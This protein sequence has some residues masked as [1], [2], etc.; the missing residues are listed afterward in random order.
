VTVTIASRHSD[1]LRQPSFV[2]V[3]MHGDADPR[4]VQEIAAASLATV[5]HLSMA[6]DGWLV[7]R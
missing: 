3:A 7:P 2:G 4:A 1:P 6:L 5:D